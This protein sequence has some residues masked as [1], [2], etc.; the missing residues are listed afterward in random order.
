MVPEEHDH[1]QLFAFLLLVVGW[2][3]FPFICMPPLHCEFML[4]LGFSTNCGLR[5]CH[6]RAVIWDLLRLKGLRKEQ[7]QCSIVVVWEV[8]SSSWGLCTRAQS[9]LSAALHAGKS[10]CAAFCSPRSPPSVLLSAE[11]SERVK[12]AA[13]SEGDVGCQACNFFL[14]T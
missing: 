3:P 6:L 8:L 14:P 1:C 7:T 4:S 10:G 5:S 9:V 13:L 12:G 11:W 2:W